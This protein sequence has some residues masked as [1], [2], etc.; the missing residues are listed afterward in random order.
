MI[1]I[2]KFNFFSEI[3][4]FWGSTFIVNPKKLKFNKVQLIISVILMEDRMTSSRHALMNWATH[5]L[6]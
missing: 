1:F 5:V 2:F 6:Q 4:T 3:S